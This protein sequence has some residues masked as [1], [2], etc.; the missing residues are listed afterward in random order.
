MHQV[1]VFIPESLALLPIR[2]E[3]V[4]FRTQPQGAA[5][6]FDLGLQGRPL[7]Q[8]RLVGD[9]YG[10]RVA[11]VLVT[12]QQPGIHEGLCHRRHSRGRVLQGQPAPGNLTGPAHGGEF[13][14]QGKH[15]AAVALLGEFVQHSIGMA[16]W[17]PA[18]PPR[19]S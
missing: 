18:T 15:D 12:D 3:P 2:G 19:A 6:P 11:G 10:D 9:L 14:Q 16:L 17:A 1:V 8:Q 7:P 4:Q 5:G 13:Q